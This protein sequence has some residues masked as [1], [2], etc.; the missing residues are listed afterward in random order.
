MYIYNITFAVRASR[1][2]K[3]LRWIRS[4]A[5][6]ALVRD[7]ASSPRLTMVEGPS[8]E[9][10][11]IKSVALQL[12]FASLA[13]FERWEASVFSTVMRDYALAFAPEP[14]FFATLLRE[15]PLE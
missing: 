2:G 9:E 13:D 15:L 7:G 1:L 10:T 11:E 4:S 8:Q 3:L 12:E 5:V 6:G 14:L